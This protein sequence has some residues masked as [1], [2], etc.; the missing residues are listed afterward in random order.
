MS[1]S[2]HPATDQQETVEGHVP[3]EPPSRSSHG[4]SSHD[5]QSDRSADVAP[6]QKTRKRPENK[7]PPEV[8]ESPETDSV[9]E[10][11]SKVNQDLFCVERFW[12][13]TASSPGNA[14]LK[15]VP[16]SFIYCLNNKMLSFFMWKINV[17]N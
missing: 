12:A 3:K 1:D 16:W 4:D 13:H 2:E 10:N 8:Q 15:N 5:M 17:K 7:P 14:G 11:E 9:A 6:T